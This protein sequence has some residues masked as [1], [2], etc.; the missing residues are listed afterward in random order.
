MAAGAISK[1][2]KAVFRIKK[3]FS[4][5]YRDRMPNVNFVHVKNDS[6]LYDEN[7]TRTTVYTF[8]IPQRKRFY[9]PL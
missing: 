2:Y 4:K 1:S 3:L 6:I 9:D 5:F 8:N 7:T